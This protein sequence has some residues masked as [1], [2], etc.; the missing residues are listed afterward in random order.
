M[1]ETRERP[2]LKLN[3]QDFWPVMNASG[4]RG[5]FGEGYPFHW[6][7]RW[8]GLDYTGSMLDTKTTTHLPRLGR[9]KGEG[10]APLKA[11]SFSLAEWWPN[12]IYVTFYMWLKGLVLNAVGL[13]NPSFRVALVTMRWQRRTE[14][15]SIS[16]MMIEKGEK[17][18]DELRDMVA[19]FKAQLPFFLAPVMLELNFS[20]PNAGH[21]P[22][23]LI[24][25]ISA[26]LDIVQELE[27][28]VTIKLNVL[29]PPKELARICT[30]SACSGIVISN[31]IPWGQLPQLI[32][33][34]KIARRDGS[35]PLAQFGGGGLSGAPLFPLVVKW[36]REVRSAGYTKPII[37]CGGILSEWELRI[38]IECSHVDGI[39]L[40]SVSILRPWRVQRLIRTANQ[41]FQSRASNVSDEERRVI[42]A[43]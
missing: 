11:D 12:S 22:S 23:E 6:L 33:W 4:G 39:Q 35:S 8:F 25:E 20:C 43:A 19:R 41:L 24:R 15:T 29:A 38:L 28:A 37:A 14:P 2:T 36:I 31:T 18:L 13:S 34:Q 10:N 1:T 21:D 30:H 3:G 5:F 16:F 17:G 9:K 40:G 42:Q 26:A 7:W 27:I 32:D